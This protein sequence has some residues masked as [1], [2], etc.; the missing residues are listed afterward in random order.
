MFLFFLLPVFSLAAVIQSFTIGVSTELP[1]VTTVAP[2]AQ[3]EPITVPTRTQNTYNAKIEQRLP[4][5][6]G[7]DELNRQEFF[8][9]IQNDKL[10]KSEIW[11]NV[12]KWSEKQTA[13][14][15]ADIMEF[16]QRLSHHVDNSKF[17]VERIIKNLPEALR[18]LSEIVQD[19]DITRL[20]EK[21]RIA[22]LY[23]SLED[24]VSKT[25]QWIVH[26]VSYEKNEGKQLERRNKLRK[27]KKGGI[28][29]GGV[30]A[31]NII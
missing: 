25:L 26:L 9:I 29:T 30:Q 12:E 3:V 22:N 17:R 20:Q 8:S 28:W 15:R 23:T 6:R 2:V 27:L 21:N 11:E 31:T 24:D 4:F 5:L 18:K 1:T 14:V 16:H 10:S 13:G 19:I 7:I